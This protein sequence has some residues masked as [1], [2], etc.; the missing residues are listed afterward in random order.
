MPELKRR[1]FLKVVGVGAGAMAATA[2][3]EPVEKVIP[4]LNQPEE[5]VPGIPTYYYSTCRECPAA[6][7]LEVKTR[8]GRAIKIEGNPNDPASRGSLCVRGQ[9]SLHR[10]YDPHRFAGPMKRDGD[11]LVP[12]SWDEGLGMLADALAPAA[13]AGKVAFVGGLETGTLDALIDDFLKA[14][15]ASR[16]VRFELFGYEALRSANEKLFGRDA[17]PSFSLE[18]ADVLVAFGTDFLE[19]WLNPLHNQVGYAAARRNGHGFAAFIGPRL[20]LSGSN[21]DQWIRPRPGTGVLVALALAHGVARRKGRTL[22]AKLESY[23]AEKTASRTGVEAA[24]VNRLAEQIAKASAP[25]ALPPGTE[26]IGTNGTSFAAAVQILNHVS[27]AIGK[28]V[29]FGPDQNLGKLARFRDMKELA[30]KMRGGEVAVLMIHQ[31]NPVYGVPQ[32]GFADAMARPGIFK[33]SFS[34]AIDETTAL[35]DL[36]LPDHT[37]YESWGDAEPVRGVRRLQQPTVRPLRDTRALGDVLV[38]VAARLDKADAL[39]SQQMRERIQ[40][41]WG[42]HFT[43]ALAAGGRFEPA[44]PRSVTLDENRVAEFDFEPAQIGGEGDLTL[45]AYPSLHFYDGRSARLAVLQ[46]LPD[47]VL[48]TTWGSFAEIHPRTARERR[49]ER[50]DVVRLSTEAGSIELPVFPSETVRPD[51]VAVAIGLGQ[52]P[53]APEAP[54]PDWQGRRRRVGVNVLELLPGRQDA[55][56]GG[57]AFLS[58]KVRLEAT[59]QRRPVAV[60][61]NSFDQE[62]RGFARATTLA[63]VGAAHGHAGESHAELDGHGKLADPSHLE[64]FV[65]EYDPARD[66]HPDSPYR[67]GMSIDLDACTGCGAC[68][69]ACQQENNISVVGEDNVL[70]GREMHWIRIERYVELHGDEIEVRHVP[71]LCQHCGAAPCENVCPVLATYHNDEGLNVMVPNRCIGTRYCSNNCSYKVRRF[72]HFPYDQSLTPIEGL[73]L[74]PDVTVRGKGVM[75]KCTFCVQRISA[76]KDHAIAEGRDVVEGEVVPACVQTCPSQAIVFGNLR[77][78]GSHVRKLRSDP[79]AYRALEFLYT[80]PAV[81]YLR[82]V[83]RESSET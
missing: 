9:A 80:R 76:A 36:V 10:T 45:V 24:L 81:S 82:S 77:E 23:S 75:E 62:G 22:A 34:S 5:I 16:R 20:S 51:V 41:R 33:V 38:D 14:I 72:N 74:N 42:A 68:T 52:Q 29:I 7:S 63:A 8:E 1:E 13:A 17:V 59:G 43:T 2:C 30:G 4:Y 60:V 3:K 6:C 69:S 19:S 40:A 37:P 65:P 25:L 11:R 57:L 31:V 32:V 70:I 15:G 39:G 46:E 79:R 35:A 66:A 26:L 49:L 18:R 53:V 48:K 12:I 27:G 78:P 21:T 50:G 44:Q 55:G 64:V 47:P 58:S 67:W 71:M 61:Q 73:A 56:S 83:R 28:T 54:A